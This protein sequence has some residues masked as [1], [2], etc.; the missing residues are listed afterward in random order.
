MLFSTILISTVFT[1]IDM[2]SRTYVFPEKIALVV[3]FK[4]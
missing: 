1:I 3:P 2:K 4:N